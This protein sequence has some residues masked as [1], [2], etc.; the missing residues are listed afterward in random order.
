MA[1]LS[2]AAPTRPIDPTMRV[3][4]QGVDEFPCCEIAI[5]GRCAGC[6]RPPSPRR[7]TALSRAA[8]ASRDFIRESMR[9]ADD[10]VGEH[11]LDRAEVELALA[12]V[13]LGDV[14]QP[15]LVRRVGG[16]VAVRRGRR[17]PAARPC[18][19]CRAASCRTRST[20]RC[21]E[22]IRHAVRS[23]IALAGVAGLVGQ[24]PVAELRVVAVGVEQRVGPIR[25]VE[26]GVGDRVGQPPVVGLAGELEHPA[27][28]RDGD[29]V[30]GQLADE[31]VDPFPGR[32]A[33]DRYAAA[34]RRTSFSCSSSRIRCAQ[35]PQLGRLA[36]RRARAWRRRRC[37]P[38]ASTS[39]A[40]SDAPR[41]R[42]R[43]ARS[44]HPASRLRATRT[45]SSRNSRG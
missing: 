41:N 29:P 5:R 22:Q 18:R 19:S 6:S 16:E 44:S 40:S 38:G 13:V 39:T 26:L 42:R 2:P 7:A 15:Q 10:P 14:G 45:T 17:A 34:R 32:F 4:V 30:G 1:A 20:S 33:C 11:V 3:P 35:L 27:R 8:T 12:G 37:R 31:R 9:V 23:A 28:H 36:V 24:E 25:L 43:S 21:R